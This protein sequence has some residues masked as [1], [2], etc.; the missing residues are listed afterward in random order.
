MTDVRGVGTLDSEPVHRSARTEGLIRS[1]RGFA[2][3]APYAVKGASSVRPTPWERVM[4]KGVD[5]GLRLVGLPRMARRR[6]FAPR[7]GFDPHEGHPAFAQPG[8][9]ADARRGRPRGDALRRGRRHAAPR[10]VQGGGDLL[11]GDG[12]DGQHG[13]PDR[14]A[15]RAA[16]L[17]LGAGR[18]F[19]IRVFTDAWPG[20]T[21]SPAGW[22]IRSSTTRTTPRRTWPSRA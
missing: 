8:R 18:D 9:P 14:P 5:D 15:Q 6:G 12:R 4:L 19:G 21:I 22:G 13:H 11:V 10:P 17:G 3:M 1:T 7:G 16:P 20:R 2:S